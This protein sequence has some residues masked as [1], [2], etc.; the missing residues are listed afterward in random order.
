[1]SEKLYTVVGKSTLNGKTVNRVANNINRAK[2]LARNGHTDIDLQ[3]LPK[4]MTKEAAIAYYND[5]RSSTMNAYRAANGRYV[6]QAFRWLA[7]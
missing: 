3:E 4:P 6:R 5:V 7:A 1:M 2:V